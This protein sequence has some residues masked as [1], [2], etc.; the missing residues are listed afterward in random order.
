LAVA[1]RIGPIDDPHHPPGVP[2][3]DP[4]AHAEALGQHI[5]KGYIYFAMAFS[6]LVELLNLRFRSKKKK[7]T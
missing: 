2:H 6:V 3:G 7:A 4:V 5:S 1:I